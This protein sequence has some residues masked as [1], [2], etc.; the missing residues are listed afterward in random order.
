[1]VLR[2]VLP[3]QQSLLIAAVLASVILCRCCSAEMIRLSRDYDCVK[4]GTEWNGLQQKGPDVY[5]AKRDIAGSPDAAIP[6]LLMK[7]EGQKVMFMIAHPDVDTNCD[8]LG[9]DQNI[10][11]STGNQKG[12]SG[13]PFT[14]NCGTHCISYYMYCA[15]ELHKVHELPDA[16][17]IVINVGTFKQRGGKCRWEVLIK[18]A[19]LLVK[20]GTSGHNLVKCVPGSGGLSGWGWALIVTAILLLVAFLLALTCFMVHKRRKNQLRQPPRSYWSNPS[21]GRGG[22][23]QS[24][25][26]R[27]TGNISRLLIIRGRGRKTA[28]APAAAAGGRGGRGGGIEALSKKRSDWF[29]GSTARTGYAAEHGIETPQSTQESLSNGKDKRAS[30]GSSKPTSHGSSKP[31]SRGS[32]P[33][34]HGSAPGTSKPT[35]QGSAPGSSKPTSHGSAP[36]SHGSA[37]GASKPTSHGSAPTSHGSA[38]TSHGSSKPTSRGSAPTS[39]GSAPPGASKLT[40]QG[41]A[42]TTT[43]SGGFKGMMARLTGQK[44]GTSSG[45]KPMM[46]RVSGPTAGT[47][48]GSKPTMARVSGPT[49]GTSGGSKPTARGSAGPKAGTSGKNPPMSG[50]MGNFNVVQSSYFG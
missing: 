43:P 30:R 40:S 5:F 33:T 8:L 38:P 11:S 48:G 47:S 24:L 20:H 44:T 35:S 7:P 26:A 23:G 17:H 3:L 29:G 21:A 42:P 49:A 4:E 13:F 31:T 18:D 2:A 9:I 46:A 22:G 19:R 15:Q 39:H 37:P 36:T 25:W 16:R 10:C 28:A 6:I 27:T 1:M 12:S 34:S 50:R 32:A 45:S 41:S 14:P